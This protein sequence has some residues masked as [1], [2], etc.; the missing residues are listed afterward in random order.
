MVCKTSGV[1]EL[2]LGKTALRFV[3]LRLFYTVCVFLAVTGSAHALP[4]NKDMVDNQ[5]KIGQ[6]MRPRPAGVV[7]RGTL[8]G[9]FPLR[10]EKKEDS[11]SFVNPQKDSREAIINGRR[12]FQVHC[13]PCHGDHEKTP[14]EP[15]VAGRFLAA[16]NLTAQMYKDRSD[17]SIYGT[18]HFGGLAIMPAYGWKLSPKEHWDVISYLRMVQATH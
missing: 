3:P 10:L 15:G 17:G 9:E 14:Y 4:F 1:K 16:P 13:M 7:A 12:L 11:A 8:K 2:V 5:I 18:I 6:S